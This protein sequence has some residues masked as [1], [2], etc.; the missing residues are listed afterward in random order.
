MAQYEVLCDRTIHVRADRP[1]LA[2]IQWGNA[3]TRW[4][5]WRLDPAHQDHRGVDVLG[6]VDC[7][8]SDVQRVM[9]TWKGIHRAVRLQVSLR[10]HPGERLELSAE[11]APIAA[12][13]NGRELPLGTAGSRVL[14]GARLTGGITLGDSGTALAV[15]WL[16]YSP[17]EA[18]WE[19]PAVLVSETSHE[20]QYDARPGDRDDLLQ[21]RIQKRVAEQRERER[22]A[23]LKREQERREQ[24]WRENDPVEKARAT[25]AS[26][27]H[28]LHQAVVE[29]N[30]NSVRSALGEI[31]DIEARL[32][33]VTSALFEA[34]RCRVYAFMATP[35]Q[36]EIVRILLDAGADLRAR[37]ASEE[38]PLHVALDG[39]H[40]H[41]T[42]NP[43][44][45]ALLLDAGAD[46]DA[47]DRRGRRPD[48]S[49]EGRYRHVG[50]GQVNELR[51]RLKFL[52]P[53]LGA[54]FRAARGA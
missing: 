40:E 23:T 33:A 26:A 7:K 21:R 52:G 4:P 46:P 20:H 48:E 6:A 17:E 47:K 39:W 5:Q 38:T 32:G 24:E 11:L 37:N 44:L 29:M 8:D 15:L 9:I 51:A 28:R 2:R 41:G 12:D 13:D 1:V 54:L 18:R 3:T 30:V 34:V 36:E 25:T 16:V 53:Q 27:V 10:G 49:I 35:A 22:L 45:I 31:T 50:P 43:S 19:E 42:A 14:P